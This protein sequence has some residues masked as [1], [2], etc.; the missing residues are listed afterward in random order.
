MSGGVS[1]CFYTFILVPTPQAM[2]PGR[3]GFVVLLDA[4]SHDLWRI[5]VLN[6]NVDWHGVLPLPYF[7]YFFTA[8]RSFALRDR[9]L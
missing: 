6:R 9:G 3:G 2:N 5:C 7:V 1:F 4:Y 8:T